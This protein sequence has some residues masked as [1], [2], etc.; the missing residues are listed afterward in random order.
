MRRRRCGRA[1]ASSALA[2]G[3]KEVMESRSR[4]LRAVLPLAILS[5][6]LQTASF[7]APAA[8]GD[9]FRHTPPRLCAPLTVEK[10][11]SASLHV[12]LDG[13]RSIQTKATLP[14]PPRDSVR[15]VFVSDTHGQLAD[16]DI[17]HG[18]ILCHTGDITFC[19]GGG[20][21]SL[22]GFNRQLAA[23]PHAHK[24]VIAGNHD[25]RLEQLGR[26]G[27]RRL[28]SAA[29]YLENSAV[30]LCGLHIWGSPYSPPHKR[31][32]SS[33]SAF[34]YTDEFQKNLWRYVPNDVDV[35]LTHGSADDSLSLASAISR[36][37]PYLHAHGHDHQLH[38]A[39]LEWPRAARSSVVG[40]SSGGGGGGGSGSGGDAGAGVPEQWG[41]PN[42]PSSDW[43]DAFG[44]RP[45]GTR[46][47]LITINA[48]IC[49][50]GY[51][52]VQLPVV[53]DLPRAPSPRP[54]RHTD[55]RGTRGTS[56]GTSTNRLVGRSS[57]KANANAATAAR[58]ASWRRGPPSTPSTGGGR[59]RGGGAR[60]GGRGSGRRAEPEHVQ[61]QR[62]ATAVVERGFEG[63]ADSHAATDAD[64]THKERAPPWFL[65]KR[66][67]RQQRDHAAQQA[68]PAG[69]GA[70]AGGAAEQRPHPSARHA[71]RDGRRP[72]GG[73]GGRSGSGSPGSGGRGGGNKRPRPKSPPPRK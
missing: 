15:L 7:V 71:E 25:K 19:A 17:P 67:G 54:R 5:L 53:V 30:R 59:G 36:T 52:P 60:R 38:G 26:Y 41:L 58:L 35:L 49:N 47:R 42:L 31:K 33:N 4:R 6:A 55:T 57:S 68:A 45:A 62:M 43:D 14:P 48:A 1:I 73:G 40:S 39:T 51:S 28:L 21:S 10:Y 20:L 65:R 44:H 69:A 18:D 63:A 61:Q 50:K 22:E 2:R 24:V 11:G 64:G 12:S 66:K 29:H 32:R 16:I 27:T 56:S 23:L 8:S 34:Q 13:M 3:D 9:F 37:Q 70:A 46:P 72:A